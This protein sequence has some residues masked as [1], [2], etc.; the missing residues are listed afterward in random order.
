MGLI[1]LQGFITE[2]QVILLIIVL[3]TLPWNA[4][5]LWRSA[6]RG[7]MW[8]FVI[9][10]LTDALAILEIIYILFFSKKPK[11]PVS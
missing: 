2:N 3:W 7:E 11:N 9:L 5:A 4:V 1:D 8:W 6:R 10:L